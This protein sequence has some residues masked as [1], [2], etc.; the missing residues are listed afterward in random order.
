[1]PTFSV[2][3]TCFNAASTLAQTLTAVLDQSFWDLEIIVV[4]RG[5]TD[6]TLAIARAYA[7]RSSRIK[8]IT[9]HENNPAAA[10]NRAALN[11]AG[12]RYLA[13][14]QPGD[15]WSLDKLDLVARRL[16]KSDAPDLVCGRVAFFRDRPEQAVARSSLS[17]VA[18]TV[19]DLLAGDGICTRSNVVVTRNAFTASGGFDASI[20]GTAETEWLIRLAASGRRLVGMNDIVVFQPVKDGQLL[21]DIAAWRAGWEAARKTAIRADRSLSPSTLRL[22]EATHLSRL[23][24]HALCTGA[25]RGTAFR[26]AAEALRIS[27][28]LPLRQP[29]LYGLIMAAL[30]EKASL[31]PPPSHRQWRRCTGPDQQMGRGFAKPD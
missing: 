4:D 8:L 12:G 6:E 7:S 3:I 15:L 10:C 22:A 31:L 18:L 25:G 9:Q 23:A 24:Q 14:L 28:A 26:L 29:Q 30:L 2:I 27:P 17:T 21:N 5:S 16:E 1:M 20:A 19:A 11:H 13:F